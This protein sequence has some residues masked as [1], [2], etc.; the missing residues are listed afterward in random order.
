M[1]DAPRIGR[2]SPLAQGSIATVATFRHAGAHR[3]PGEERFDAAG[4]VFTASGAWGF[5]SSTATGT[6]D[7]A[8][9]VVADA[10]V[11]YACRHE[12][13]R[14]GDRTLDVTFQPNIRLDPSLAAGAALVP[15]TPELHG[16]RTRLLAAALAVDEVAAL[17]F[18]LAAADLLGAVFAAGTG[19]PAGHRD[20]DADVV[21]AALA[22][23]HAHLADSLDLA[24][25]ASAAALSPFHFAR[26]FRRRV[27]EPPVRH[28]RRLR[29]ERAALLLR[30]TDRSVTEIA[31]D[32]GF[33][34]VSNFV[35]LFRAAFGLSPARWRRA[36]SARIGKTAA[37]VGATLTACGT[38]RFSA[39]ATS[40]SS[41]SGPPSASSATG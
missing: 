1:N 11:D 24:T 28:V 38:P 4:V 22:H 40:R 6:A 12:E 8:H 19:E 35:T 15:V 5:R 18:D 3:D 16:A 33:G 34:S 23:V 32:A 2:F 29:L 9:A 39:A 25:L 21:D 41:G 7:A 26:L 20:P 14:P 37:G 36:R 30:E 31:L 13:R 10:G 17:R 27:G